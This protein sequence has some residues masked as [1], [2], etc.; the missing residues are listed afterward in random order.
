M[1]VT[2]LEN[3]SRG[4]PCLG[5]AGGV[6]SCLV[7]FLIFNPPLSAAGQLRGAVSRSLRPACVDLVRDIEDDTPADEVPPGLHQAAMAGDLESLKAF[8]AAGAKLDGG[9]GLRMDTALMAAAAC[10]QLK[11]VEYLLGRGA[12]IDRQGRSGRSALMWATKN[13]HLAVVLL[14][15]R[16]GA[17][18]DSEDLLR[19]TARDLAA[20]YDQ[21]H[22]LAELA[23]RGA[24]T[25]GQTR[26]PPPRWHVGIAPGLSYSESFGSGAS[27][28]L[29][30]GKTQS[31]TYDVPQSSGLLVQ[32]EH[33]A[34]ARRIA[35]GVHGIAA[36]SGVF[37]LGWGAGFNLAV[38]DIEEEPRLFL[39]SARTTLI[40]PELQTV[41]GVLKFRVAYLFQ[42][43]TDAGDRATPGGLYL[44]LGLGF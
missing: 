34:S 11:V 36:P 41:F 14:L 31:P 2:Y 3:A 25:G 33:F 27:I 19:N 40:G 32:V 18:P 35:V 12:D 38:V 10:G 28:G 22:V 4:N 17:N 24:R 21:P 43:R 26:T 16:Y 13:G 42:L 7:L 39:E 9:Y 44:S 6:V 1:Y 8:L 5:R 20:Y 30:L 29:Y 23:A 15:L 37:V